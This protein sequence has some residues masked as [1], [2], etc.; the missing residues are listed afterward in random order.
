MG[1]SSGT[2]G[3]AFALEMD[4]CILQWLLTGPILV[5]YI[6]LIA[7]RTGKLESSPQM[8]EL[9]RRVKEKSFQFG[10]VVY[11]VYILVCVL[12]C[13]MDSTSNV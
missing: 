12:F 11:F 6:K 10:F 13:V 7:G 4:V 8:K 5:M 9:K 3:L 2:W 1:L